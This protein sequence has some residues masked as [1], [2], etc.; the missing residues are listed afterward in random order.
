MLFE[1]I[2]SQS[3]AKTSNESEAYSS[4]CAIETIYQVA[5]IKRVYLGGSQKLVTIFLDEKDFVTS[6]IEYHLSLKKQGR[7][8]GIY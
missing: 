1:K 3:Y 4:S 2:S 7:F 6:S 8:F 5:S